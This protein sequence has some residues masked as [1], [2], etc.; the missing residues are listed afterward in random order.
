MTLSR[1]RRYQVY[2][3]TTCPKDYFMSC[4]NPINAYLEAEHMNKRHKMSNYRVYDK[5][6]KKYLS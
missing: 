6:L 4:G 2:D 5:K 3:T 1:K